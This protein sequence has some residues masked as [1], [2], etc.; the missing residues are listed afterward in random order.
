MFG[1]T[2]LIPDHYPDLHGAVIFSNPTSHGAP[3]APLPAADPRPRAILLGADHAAI[4]IVHIEH[5]I[6]GPL[7]VT[8]TRV[9]ASGWSEEAFRLSWLDWSGE[10]S[11]L[12]GG[13]SPGMARAC[14][15]KDPPVDVDFFTLR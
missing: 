12:F 13:W 4:V 2:R 6:L 15:E 3:T 7:E 1:E 14:E 11:R 5:A 10:R 8:A 9:G